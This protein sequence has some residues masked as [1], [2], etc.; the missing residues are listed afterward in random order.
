MD[1]KEKMG[2]GKN[3]N[4]SLEKKMTEAWEIMEKLKRWTEENP[5]AAKEK[6][7]WAKKKYP[8]LAKWMKET[9][10]KW[11]QSEKKTEKGK[12]APKAQLKEKQPEKK[13]SGSD[14]FY[15]ED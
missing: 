8:G 10:M 15:R 9:K 2:N 11:G 3:Q 4:P 7:S 14:W 13:I 12:N 5:K 6:M 1:M